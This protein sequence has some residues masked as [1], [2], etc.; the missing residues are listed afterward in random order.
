M[1]STNHFVPNPQC[2]AD[3]IQVQKL[4]QVVATDQ[5]PDHT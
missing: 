5:M 3:E 2:L 4:I 1:K